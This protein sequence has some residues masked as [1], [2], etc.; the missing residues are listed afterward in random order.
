MILA[1]KRYLVT[2]M[3]LLNMLSTL[4]AE[5]VVMT[6][7]LNM[8]MIENKVRKVKN[9]TRIRKWRICAVK[10]YSKM[11]NYKEHVFFLGGEWSPLSL[12]SLLAYC[13]GSIRYWMMMSGSNLWNE[14]QRKP[15]YSEI[16]APVPLCQPQIPHDLT[17]A[18]TRSAAV[19]N[20]RLTA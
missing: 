10:C 7:L 9:F 11:L 12:R 2:M 13:I 16:P 18:Q 3:R 20:R 5:T 1:Q 17:R 6:V 15:K 8:V 19:G 4:T 14:W